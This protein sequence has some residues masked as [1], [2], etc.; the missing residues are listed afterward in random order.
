[1]GCSQ[2]ALLPGEEVRAATQTEVRCCG[3][4]APL[5]PCSDVYIHLSSDHYIHLV[6]EPALKIIPDEEPSQSKHD[7]FRHCCFSIIQTK[8]PVLLDSS[9]PS[10][11]TSLGGVLPSAF[12]WSGSFFTN[13]HF[14]VVRE[15]EHQM[16]SKQLCY[17]H[18]HFGQGI[19]H[20]GLLITKHMGTPNATEA[21]RPH[22]SAK[23][24]RAQ[25]Y[26]I[27]RNSSFCLGEIYVVFPPHLQHAYMLK[28]K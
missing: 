12:P 21:S 23:N 19:S 1:M 16:V 13:Y 8:R 17:R 11:S 10:P 4:H 25:F 18:Q 28:H 22:F 26:R 15:E 3:S 2:G 6:T 24:A 20:P 7:P 14:W 9:P 5:L 27:H